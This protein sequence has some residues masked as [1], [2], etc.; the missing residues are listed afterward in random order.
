MHLLEFST[1]EEIVADGFEIAERVEIP[2]DGDSA[3]DI[4]KALAAGVAG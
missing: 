1:F 2:L 4:G 3:G